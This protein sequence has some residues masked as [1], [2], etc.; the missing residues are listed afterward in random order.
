MTR[1]ARPRR[2]PALLA[3]ALL[4]ALAPAACGGG[5]VAEDAPAPPSTGIPVAPPNARGAPLELAPPAASAPAP[6][7]QPFRHAPYPPVAPETP[8]DPAPAEGAA[9]SGVQL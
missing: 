2:A 9:E 1:A 3:G 5:D 7:P 6:L 8:E 4:A